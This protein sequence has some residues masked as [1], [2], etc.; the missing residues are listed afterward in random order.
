MRKTVTETVNNEETGEEEEI[1]KVSRGWNRV[2][3]K[4]KPEDRRVER[5]Y[6]RLDREE[7]VKGGK[8]D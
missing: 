7:K 5:E 6:G 4:V 3:R 2:V 1:E 8:I